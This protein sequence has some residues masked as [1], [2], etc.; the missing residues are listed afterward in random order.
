MTIANQGASSGGSLAKRIAA[1]ERAFSQ[2]SEQRVIVKDAFGKGKKLVIIAKRQGTDSAY[3]GAAPFSIESITKNGAN[4]KV[5]IS[6]GWVRDL[7]TIKGGNG[8][9][10]FMP[11]A[12]G[13]ELS[14]DPAPEISMSPGDKLYC[15]YTT[16]E[17]GT[18]TG[19]ATVV[20][21]KK[22]EKT[23]HYQPKDAS[24]TGG[25]K[26]EY[27]IKLGELAAN[28]KTVTWKQYQNS[29]IEHVHELETFHNIGDG[30]GILKKR[31]PA[32]DYYEARKVKGLFGILQEEEEERVTLDLDAQNV[33]D[34]E[35]LIVVPDGGSNKGSDES[36][37][38]RSIRAAKA[39]DL[40]GDSTPQIKVVKSENVL[41]VKGNN[42]SGKLV[43]VDCDDNEVT[44]LEWSD[45][46][47]TTSATSEGIKI[48]LGEC[49][50]RSSGS[51]TP[52]PA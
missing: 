20:T 8:I 39:A 25:D 33:G 13:S 5:I 38:I 16:D 17:T 35:Q 11:K 23:I 45:G 12:G 34:G 6:P 44:I 7:L 1:L 46:L 24:A 50:N 2:Y 28:G 4:Y 9:T 14:S 47:V 21:S 22:D 19:D 42:M 30:A 40:T 10:F 3:S 27:W 37:K 51:D 48:N 15:K 49:E 32:A 52:P 29:D 41:V 31:N 26:G 18:I 43:T 36:M